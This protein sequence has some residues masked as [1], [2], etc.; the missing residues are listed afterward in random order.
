MS[1][2]LCSELSYHLCTASQELQSR[3]AVFS[4]LK[5]VTDR[6]A[7]KCCTW[8]MLM[9]VLK[10]IFSECVWQACLLPCLLRACHLTVTQSVSVTPIRLYMGP[11]TWKQVL[12][13]RAS[14]SSQKSKSGLWN[15]DTDVQNT[16]QIPYM[17]Q[18][19]RPGRLKADDVPDRCER[20]KWGDKLLVSES[21]PIIWDL[22]KFSETTTA[23][24]NFAQQLRK[25]CPHKRLDVLCC[26][27]PANT[28]K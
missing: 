8:L 20:R 15:L 1:A 7:G 13:R 22:C 27:V 23:M 6:D 16:T 14:V 24:L 4:C 18:G 19:N 12:V 5:L 17:T 2:I 26:T 28:Q 9:S 10:G 11:W 3:L 21:L 25:H